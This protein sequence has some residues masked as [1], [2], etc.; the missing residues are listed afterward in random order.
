MKHRDLIHTYSIIALDRD[1]GLMGGAVQSHYFSVGGTVIWAEAG[2]GVIATQAMVNMDYGPEGLYLLKSGLAAGEVVKKLTGDDS[3]AEIR[4]TAAL[5]VSGR[6]AAFTG[7][8]TIREAGHITG[9][10]FS[11][12]ANMMLKDTVPTAMA[13][14]FEKAS[15][16]LQ[17]RLLEA[18][19]AAE[20]EGGDIRG[21]QSAA[22]LIVSMQDRGN[23]RDNTTVDLRVEDNPEP[24]MELE[25][26]LNVQEAYY[27]ADQGDLAIESGDKEKATAEFL[28]AEMLQ[29]ENIELRFWKAVSLLNS[30]S[31]DDAAQILKSIISADRNWLELLSRLLDAGILTNGFSIFEQLKK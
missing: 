21:M 6:T 1:S 13:E 8:N 9:K 3:A 29:P 14:T 30:G 16:P 11:V 26:L 2:V 31:V 7:K 22:M 12:Q 28:R 10:G 20:A 18:L 27:H 25:R 19:K 4:Q 15:G 24:L 17:K 23:V 5:D